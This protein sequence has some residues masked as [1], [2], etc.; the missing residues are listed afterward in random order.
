M[1]NPDSVTREAPPS[2]SPSDVFNLGASARM[3]HAFLSYHGLLLPGGEAESRML[4]KFVPPSGIAIDVGANV[5]Q[6]TC[7]LSRLAGPSGRV[8]AFEP[9]D[10][11]FD[12]LQRVLRWTRTSNVT[13][14]PVALSDRTGVGELVLPEISLKGERDGY[15]RLRAPGEVDPSQSGPRVETT[16]LD[17]EVKARGIG[18]IDFIK[19]DAEGG[20]WAVF[21]GGAESVRRFR[22]TILCEIEER[23][24]ILNG[25]TAQETFEYILGL[26]DY[27]A[28]VVRQGTLQ[29]T[30]GPNEEFRNLFF[31]R[32]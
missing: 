13:A 29:R 15:V 7:V 14:R 1:P 31:C 22:P 30:N 3:V 10:R 20:E 2:S 4:G 26:G 18:R 11:S 8:L 24:T 21:H 16:T 12:R 5:G 28:Y 17:D 9:Y 6:Y 27:S 25:H 23:W 19:C 32:S